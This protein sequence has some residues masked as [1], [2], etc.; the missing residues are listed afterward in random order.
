MAEKMK[1]DSL[2]R[3][4]T[5]GALADKQDELMSRMEEVLEEEEMGTM[6]EMINDIRDYLTSKNKLDPYLNEAGVMQIP[7]EMVFSWFSAAIN[8]RKKASQD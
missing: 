7:L 5:S 2:M 6:D 4:I 1:F 8:K 3:D